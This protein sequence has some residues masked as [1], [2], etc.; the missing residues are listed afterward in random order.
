[1]CEQHSMFDVGTLIFSGLQTLALFFALS[2]TAY[3]AVRQLRAY[4]Y[5]RFK[6]IKTFSLTEPI[7]ITVEL[8][9]AGQTPAKDCETTGVVFVGSLPLDDNSIMPEPDRRRHGRGVIY[10]QSEITFDCE[11]IDLLNNN[12]M[13]DGLRAG[14]AAIY[15]AGK[16]SYKDMFNC[17]RHTEFCWYIDPAHA[18]LLIDHERGRDVTVPSI[19]NFTLAHVWNRTT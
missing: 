7:E 8:K 1:M 4:V 12:T 5:P 10:P 17:K 16:V 19:I 6:N 18:R 14:S 11:S 9:N 2:I 15:V 3:V 13:I